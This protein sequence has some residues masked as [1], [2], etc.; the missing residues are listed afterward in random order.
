MLLGWCVTSDAGRQ[1]ITK[2]KLVEPILSVVMPALC[3]KSEE[4]EAA[5]V[6]EESNS[7]VTACTRLI[8]SLAINLPPEKL[9][10][11]LVSRAGP[12][13][14]GR[15]KGGERH[16]GGGG[17]SAAR[18]LSSLAS[19]VE[20]PAHWRLFSAVIRQCSVKRRQIAR[21]QAPQGSRCG[22]DLIGSLHTVYIVQFLLK[23]R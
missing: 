15:Q 20:P 4:D 14:R 17:Q 8:D 6:T 3:T 7:L 23:Y 5:E 11:P 9:L 12:G 13:G 19:S 10:A 1:V 21:F 16:W 18:Y 2:H 22:N